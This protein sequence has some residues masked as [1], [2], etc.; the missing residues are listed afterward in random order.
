MKNKDGS[1]KCTKGSERSKIDQNI[2]RM[3][4]VGGSSLISVFFKFLSNEHESLR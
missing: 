1:D 2:V 4:S 3:D